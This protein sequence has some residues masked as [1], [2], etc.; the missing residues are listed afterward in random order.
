MLAAAD[1]AALLVAAGG[2][3]LGPLSSTQALWILAL[4][5]LWL[6]SAKL[7]GLY[8][9]DHRS[10]R[11]LTVDELGAI[12]SWGG[13]GTAGAV[14]I[15]SLSPGGAPAAGAAAV[16]WLLLVTL[17]AAFRGAARVLWRSRTAPTRIL[18]AGSGPLAEA[19]RRKLELFRDMHAQVAGQIDAGEL[20]GAPGDGRVEHRIRAACGGELPD[21]IIVCSRDVSEG[22]LAGILRTCRDQRIKLSVVPP[23]RGMFGTAVR[24]SHVAEM[25]LVEY[26]T[27][28]QSNSTML[29]KRSCD[30]VVAAVLLVIS[31]PFLLLTAVA[32][33]IDSPGPVFFRQRRAGLNGEPFLMV[34][35]RTMVIAAEEAPVP[36]RPGDRRVTRVGKVLRR[37]SLD[38]LP[39]LV[40]V[41]RGTMSLVGPRPEE[42]RVVDQYAPDHRF[43]LEAKPGMTGPMQVFGRGHLGIA[44]RLAVE[45]EYIENISIGRDL[46]ILMH[47]LPAVVSGRGAF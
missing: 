12:V 28:D 15:L 46:H 36:K 11:H 20:A 3:H 33:R 22:L 5:P 17:D 38:E 34:K 13:V 29:L 26:H 47:T 16:F 18:L 30:I 35:F 44:E 23:L 19:A 25:P 2:A 6:V 40:H 21:R 1:I 7:Y 27:W 31:A 41:L 10:L 43:R 32:I 9:R 8:D 24:L 45:R 4:L 42:L 14:L 39:Q 37:W